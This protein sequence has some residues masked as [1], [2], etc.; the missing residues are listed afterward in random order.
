M[1]EKIISFK[2]DLPKNILNRVKEGYIKAQDVI[3]FLLKT[4]DYSSEVKPNETSLSTLKHTK[5][6][7]IITHAHIENTTLYI[8]ISY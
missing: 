8:E 3:D 1:F 6:C 5:Y 4:N 7:G 2:Y